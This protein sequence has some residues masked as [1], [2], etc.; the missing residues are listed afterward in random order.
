MSD[1]KTTWKL[2]K[3]YFVPENLTIS[4][5]FSIKSQGRY[6]D[7]IARQSEVIFTMTNSWVHQG[8]NQEVRHLDN[9]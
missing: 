3:L 8:V 6:E 1:V 7:F 2:P 9:V 4:Q 5:K